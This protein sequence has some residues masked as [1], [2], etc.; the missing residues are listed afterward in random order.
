VVAEVG[1]DSRGKAASTGAGE[2]VASSG[3]AQVHEIVVGGVRM[4]DQTAI[5][6][7]IYDPS[8]EGIP[9]D[10]MIGFELFRRFAVRLDYGAGTMTVS[11]FAHFDSR[12]AGTAVP[13]QFYD[14]LPFVEGR[15]GDMPARFD[16]DTG[17]RVEVDVTSPFVARAKLRERYTKGI[18][19]ITGWGAGGPSRDYVVRIPSLTLGTVKVD[20]VVA[21]LS[22]DKGGSISDSNYEGNIG[23]GLLK[24]FVVTF[25]YSRQVMYL[26]RL[27]TKPVDVGLFDR[28]G[29]WINAE[30]GGYRVT[31]VAAGSPATEGGI[32]EGD[33]ITAIDGKPV[34]SDQLSDARTMLRALPAG[35][36]L[37]LKLRRGEAERTTNITL[38]DQI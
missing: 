3:F 21:G 20:D 28:S 7:T 25:D 32:A 12:D 30:A 11:D 2:K 38:R 9:V 35:T 26:N 6:T 17:S 13:F 27:V 14:H 18:S 8:I 31:A 5:I 4:R 29:L 37:S 10:G 23:S 24:Q 36:R 16:I 22:E 1:L 34:L 19:T 15:I 33:V